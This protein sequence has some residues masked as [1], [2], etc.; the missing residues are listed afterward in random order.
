MIE[1]KKLTYTW[2]Y[3]ELGGNSFVTFELFPDGSQTR[4]KLTHQGLDTFPSN[5][6]NFSKDSFAAGW[7]H[8]I[9]SSLKNFLEENKG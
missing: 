3:K 7:T 2:I 9:G 5:D 6:S 1:K 8:I 4:L